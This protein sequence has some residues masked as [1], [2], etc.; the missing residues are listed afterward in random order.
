M[1][2]RKGIPT[3]TKLRLFSAAAGHCQNPDCLRPLFPAEMGGDKHIAEMAHV[4]PHGDQGP[5]HED[6]PDE[7]FNSDSFDNLILLCPTCHTIIDKDPSA[8]P[9][10]KLLDWKFNHLASLANRQGI[11]SYQERKQVRDAVIPVMAENR[12]VWAEFAPS[13]GRRFS[14]DPESES[15]ITWSQRMRSVILPNHFRIQAIIQA[16]TQLMNAEEHEIFSQYKE[17]VR[18]LSERHICGVSGGAIRYPVAM[19][20]IFS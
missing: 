1:A 2:V 11:I 7:E 12:A 18:G 14:Y 10:N 17:H 4:I 8:Y 5:R 3:E 13:D 16:N 19:D 9:R 20:G 6:R 15:A